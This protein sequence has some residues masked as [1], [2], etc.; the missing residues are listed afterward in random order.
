MKKFL[1]VLKASLIVILIIGAICGIVCYIVIPEQTKSL[2]DEVIV[3]VNQPLPIVGVSISVV[4]VFI[5]K[6]FVSTKYGQSQ[7]EKFKLA[8][9]DEKAKYNELLEKVNL[10]KDEYQALINSHQAEIDYLESFIVKLC[11]TSSNVKI[12]ALADD[13]KNSYEAKKNAI[14]CDIGAYKSQ[15]LDLYNKITVED[16]NDLKNQLSL[17]FEDLKKELINNGKIEEEKVNNGSKE[18]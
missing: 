4:L 2:I 3:F 14:A 8:V 11:E 12:K 6:L 18:E 10:K 1:Q 16:I 5:Y 9:E 13:L 7:I 15:F 17:Q